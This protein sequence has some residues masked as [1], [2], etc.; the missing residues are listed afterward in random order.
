MFYFTILAIVKVCFFDLLYPQFLFDCFT[1]IVMFFLYIFR[2][3]FFL[4]ALNLLSFII[5]RFFLEIIQIFC[6]QPSVKH[7]FAYIF[8]V[9]RTWIQV[10]RSWI[11]FHQSK[12]KD[13]NFLDLNFFVILNFKISII[14]L[15]FKFHLF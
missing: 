10:Y 7:S 1:L 15:N 2:F 12:N 13:F 14:F 5:L 3:H 11:A 4:R 9:R 8:R 6:L